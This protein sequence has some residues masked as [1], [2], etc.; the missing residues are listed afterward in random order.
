MESDHDG[1]GRDRSGGGRARDLPGAGQQLGDAFH[2][3][4][5]QA[6]DHI[7]QEGLGID[8][9]EPAVF[10]QREEIGQPRS[11]LGMAD[12]QPVL[13]A[14]FER[15]NRLL[16]EVV[17]EACAP[18]GQTAQERGLLP[19]QITERLAEAGFRRREGSGRQRVDEEPPAMG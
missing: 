6:G 1:S 15:T 11:G 14:Q 17:I 3:V 10:D 4:I 9:G 19:E 2:G 7:E 12:L 18:F 5:G 13:G 8:P 16:D